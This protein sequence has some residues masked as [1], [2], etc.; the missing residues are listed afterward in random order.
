MA[1]RV[2]V[3]GAT[4][5]GNRVPISQIRNMI[6]RAG[7]DHYGPVA[8]AEIVIDENEADI[9]DALENPESVMVKSHLPEMEKIIFHVMSEI[10]SARV[11]DE[12]T[13][14]KWL[15]R[16][17]AFFQ[18]GKQVA[19][20]KVFEELHN[21]GMVNWDGR[22]V[23]SKK[24]GDIAANFYFHPFDVAAWRDNFSR[25]FSDGLEVYDEAVAWALGNVPHFK[26]TGSF[27]KL[28]E[29]IEEFKSRLPLGLESR[30]GSLVTEIV[31]W[32]VTGGPSIGH[33]RNQALAFREDFGRVLKV[34]TLLNHEMGWDMS[35]FFSDLKFR[36]EKAIPSN[37]LEFCQL[38]IPKGQAI[39][40]YNMGVETREELERLAE[41]HETVVDVA[42]R[43]TD[44]LS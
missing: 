23:V 33:L 42:R 16:S 32:Y 29:V 17:F 26:V 2:I 30:N 5:A 4:R 6:G 28:W 14:E 25:L 10:S 24:V 20:V 41:D 9:E 1:D 21:V 7:R 18:E 12:K 22:Y 13:A 27:G 44:E 11:R 34:L 40:L 8:Q 36:V 43:V 19:F 31:W 15:S 35:G 38:G 3:V 37:L 39:C